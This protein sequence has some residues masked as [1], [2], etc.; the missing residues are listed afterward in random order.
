M[1]EVVEYLEDRGVEHLVHFTPITNLGGIKKRGILPRNEIDG[2]PDIVFEALD[3]VRLDERT[4]MSCFSISFPN[5][6]MMYRYRTKLWS[7]EEDVALLFI[8]ISVLSDLEYDQV[9]FCPSNAASRECRR[10]D[11]QDLLGLAAAEKLFVEEMTTRSGV[12]FS[13]QSE[14]LPDFLTTNPQAEIQIAA[15]I[16]WEKVS[17]VVV[18]DYETKQSLLQSGIHRNVYAKWE[19][20][21]DSSLNVFKYPSY[22]RAWVDAAGDLHG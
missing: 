4:D 10:T 5:F 11:P 21:N 3:E 18:N 14:D 2:F 13:R 1:R 20:N 17:F 7:R 22:W 15:T 19:V 8:P 6:L 16:P 9:V 12:V